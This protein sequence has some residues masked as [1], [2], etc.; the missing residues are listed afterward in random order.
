MGSPVPLNY[1]NLFMG[2]VQLDF[3]SDNNPYSKFMKMFEIYR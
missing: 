2:K 3:E 1:A